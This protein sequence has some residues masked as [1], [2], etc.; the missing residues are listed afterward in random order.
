LNISIRITLVLILSSL[1]VCGCELFTTRDPQPPDGA[2]G[3]GW[4]FP[5]EP[6]TVLDN[7]SESVGRR[8]SVDYLRSF[9]TSDV[10]LPEMRF[11]ADP[12]SAANY[13]GLFDDWG[14]RQETAFVG[15]LF[16][17]SNLPLD[18]LSELTLD[19]Q[20]T[21]VLGDSA[22]ITAQYSLHLGHLRESAPRVVSGRFDFEILRGNDGGWY[23]QLWSDY[24]NE[25]Q[26]CWSDLKAQF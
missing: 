10:G 24:R 1:L 12:G 11:V 9:A 22:L 13:P 18:S 4:Q 8:S 21:Q 25:G 17:S 16:S 14:I 19:M 6:R 7:L 26:A 5:S 20:R 15:S 23:V 2:N 3:G